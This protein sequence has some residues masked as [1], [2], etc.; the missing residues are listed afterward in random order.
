MTPKVSCAAGTLPLQLLLEP[1]EIQAFTA[2]IGHR[3]VQITL[4]PL[5]QQPIFY[6]LKR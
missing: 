3:V 4:R 2:F 1:S 6:K 5:Q